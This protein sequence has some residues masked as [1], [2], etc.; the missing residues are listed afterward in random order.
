MPTNVAVFQGSVSIPIIKLEEFLIQ[1]CYKVCSEFETYPTFSI[2]SHLHLISFLFFLSLHLNSISAA[3]DRVIPLSSTVLTAVANTLCS[4]IQG[5]KIT[6]EVL[7]FLTRRS[8]TVMLSLLFV[9]PQR[10]ALLSQD[11]WMWGA[12]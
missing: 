8:N 4:S 7:L 5:S 2:F 3:E 11:L 12:K 6:V 9:V 10:A 1:F